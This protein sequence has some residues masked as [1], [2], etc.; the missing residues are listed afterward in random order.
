M[1]SNKSGSQY[2]VT[3]S[4][5]LSHHTTPQTCV[6]TGIEMI[7]CRKEWQWSKHYHSSRTDVVQSPHNP[8]AS[9]LHVVV[10]MAVI[11]RKF[12]VEAAYQI[13]G[14]CWPVELGVLYDVA[15][16]SKFHIEIGSF[17]GKS[18]F[19]FVC[20]MQPNSRAICI[21]PIVLIGPN[22]VAPSEAWVAGVLSTTINE[23]RRLRPDVEISH[24]REHSLAASPQAATVGRTSR[25]DLHRRGPQFCRSDSRH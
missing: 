15:E 11:E 12:A 19:P 6:P 5:L 2:V 22:Y 21:D 16:R 10:P 3:H 20:G 25:H 17:C 9:I 1:H 24:C 14:W 4:F 18:F 13:P 7:G 8:S 23:L